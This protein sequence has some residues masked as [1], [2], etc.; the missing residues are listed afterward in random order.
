MT[1]TGSRAS[2]VAFC[3]EPYRRTRPTATPHRAAQLEVG[4]EASVPVVLQHQAQSRL[5]LGVDAPPRRARSRARSTARRPLVSASS[6]RSRSS[7][8]RLRSAGGSPRARP[9]TGG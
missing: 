6:L 2:S 1:R 3:P 5:G 8:S 4:S 9:P 7:S